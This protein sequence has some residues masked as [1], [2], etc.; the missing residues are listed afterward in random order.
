MVFFSDFEE[1]YSLEEAMGKEPSFRCKF[2][3]WWF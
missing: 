3:D 2:I 1:D